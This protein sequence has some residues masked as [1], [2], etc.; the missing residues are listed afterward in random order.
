MEQVTFT[1]QD[2]QL[3]LESLIEHQHK[4]Y[5]RSYLWKRMAKGLSMQKKIEMYEEF[6]EIV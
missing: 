2:F 1:T 3:M 6:E 5:D 4:L